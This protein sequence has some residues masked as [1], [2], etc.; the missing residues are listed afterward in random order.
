[1]AA[2][3]ALAFAQPAFSGS[4]EKKQ[5]EADYKAAKAECKKLNEAERTTCLHNAKA[6]HEAEEKGLRAQH[7]QAE[8]TAKAEH[9]AAEAAGKKTH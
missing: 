5:A 8:K 7:E 9:E 2:L 4:V 1:M 6:A 3:C